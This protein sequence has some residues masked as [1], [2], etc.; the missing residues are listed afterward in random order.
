MR[1]YE[2]HTHSMTHRGHVT[3]AMRAL[4]VPISRDLTTRGHSYSTCR[5][6]STRNHAMLETMLSLLSS[7]HAEPRL[8][9]ICG[10]EPLWAK[11]LHDEQRARLLRRL[12][13]R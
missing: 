11:L 5:V 7:M 3:C 2:M 1:T 10:A 9:S 12:L 8:N 13:R 6:P 4:T